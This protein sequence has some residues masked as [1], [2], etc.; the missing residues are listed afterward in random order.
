MIRGIVTIRSARCGVS[1][2]RRETAMTLVRPPSGS[3]PA[4]SEERSGGEWHHRNREKGITVGR[5][6]Q[7]RVAATAEDGH[8]HS[9][10]DA[11]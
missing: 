11:A 6:E 8:S 2:E 9:S 3:K 4:A 1:G 5:D 7:E 10:H